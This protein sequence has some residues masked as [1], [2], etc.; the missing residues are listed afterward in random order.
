MAE[1][2]L[3]REKKVWR[4][5]NYVNAEKV[6]IDEAHK[7]QTVN[8]FNCSNSTLHIPQKVN[9]IFIDKGEKLVVI[10][11]GVVGTLVIINSK[12]IEIRVSETVPSFQIEQSNAVRLC[13]SEQ[14]ASETEI[15]SN[16]ATDVNVLIVDDT[17][18]EQKEHSLPEQ[19]KSVYRNGK[20]LTTAVSK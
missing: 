9:A 7:A 10:V 11:H 6:D 3:Y 1:P 19:L 8:I 16:L 18:V 2:K 20:F 5:E 17:V 15:L 12:N 13:L 4:V 14:C